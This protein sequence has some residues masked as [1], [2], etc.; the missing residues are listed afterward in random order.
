MPRS[1]L[2]RVAVLDPHPAVRAGLHAVLSAEP[3]LVPAGAAADEEALWP[4]LHR[5]RPGVLLV[6]HVPGASDGL[7]L[8]RRVKAGLLGPKV[9]VCATG[10]RRE[11][12]V[13]AALAGADALVG[14]A[15][16]LAEL[17]RAIRAVAGGERVLDRVTPRLQSEAGARL[18]HLDR[19]IFA[20]RLAG[21]SPRD[22]AAT[23]G[24]TPRALDARLGRI[25]AVLGGGGS[26]AADPW[27]EGDAPRLLPH[28]IGDAA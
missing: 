26:R 5:T 17:L 20:M 6:D 12:A 23:T 27:H 15:D 14:K 4:L 2:V 8:A 19:A 22:I 25:V 11:L 18:G 3:D 1:P 21:T 24:L 16:D 28:A 10:P 9:V 7:G 13:G